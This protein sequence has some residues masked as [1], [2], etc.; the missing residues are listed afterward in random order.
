MFLSQEWSDLPEVER[1]AW[2]EQVVY[3]VAFTNAGLLQDCTLPIT[4]AD[5]L[6]EQ[7]SKA[8]MV[9]LRAYS[10]VVKEVASLVNWLCRTRRSALF[11]G[12]SGLVEQGL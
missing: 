8:E 5:L 10:K 4:N 2:S 9:A 1:E 11:W 12:C 3:Y 6:Q 7:E